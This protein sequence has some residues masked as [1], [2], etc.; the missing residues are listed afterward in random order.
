MPQVIPLRPAEQLAY[1]V[2]VAIGGA[3]IV[4]DLEWRERVAG[5]YCACSTVSGARLLSARYLAL[6]T[7]LNAREAGLPGMPPGLLI[8]V[9]IGEGRAPI[10][11]DEL[12]AGVQLQYWTQEEIAA[13]VGELVTG[14][15]SIVVS[16]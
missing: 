2:R 3:E 14:I 1:K 16:E 9:R 12:G 6:D 15:A 13:A 10:S 5:W 7:A 8:P 11:K 4:L